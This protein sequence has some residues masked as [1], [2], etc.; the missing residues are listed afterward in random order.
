MHSSQ[1]E[2]EAGRGIQQF[3]LDIIL[4][5][6]MTY[7]VQQALFLG[8]PAEQV[9]SMLARFTKFLNMSEYHVKKLNSML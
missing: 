2:V 8:R 9:K 6:K 7:V 3:N 4:F 1:R 5:D